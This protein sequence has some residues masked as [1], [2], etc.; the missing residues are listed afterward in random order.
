MAKR[1]F[2]VGVLA[3]FVACKSTRDGEKDEVR[4]EGGGPRPVAADS[5]KD[6]IENAFLALGLDGSTRK[7]DLNSV[8]W[9]GGKIKVARVHVLQD[10]ILLEGSGAQP[11]VY[12]VRRSDLRPLWVSELQEPTAFPV[13]ESDDTF[14]LVSQHYLHALEAKTGQRAMQF[15]AGGLAGLRRPALRLPFTPSGGGAGQN[16]TVYVASLGSPIYNKTLESF[17]LVTGQRGWG[18]RTPGDILTT[19][20]VGGSSGDPKLYWVTSNGIATCIDARNYAYAPAGPRWEERLEADVDHPFCLTEDTKERAGGVFVADQ[21]GM[22]YCLDRITG[23]RRWVSATARKPVGGPAVFGD[24]CVV[25]MAGGFSCFDS[26][27]VLY[28]VAVADGPA[29]GATYWVGSGPAVTLGSDPKADMSVADPSLAARHLAFEVQGEVLTV[30]AT[31]SQ[32]LS[33]N[34]GA[35]VKN[36]TAYGGDRIAVGR[37]VLVVKDR[38]TEALWHDLSQER[39]VGRVGSKLIAASGTTLTV[40]D[41][42]SGEAGASATLPGA[43]FIGTNTAD[44]ALYAVGGDAV[45]YG[46]FPR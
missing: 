15:V 1:L 37:T 17:S 10:T 11:N 29:K 19:P 42:W 23:A 38:G 30:R 31:G 40:V 46:F 34:G 6:P 43:R 7:L 36:A 9:K 5:G 45:L 18:Y 21:A 32:K 8:E 2:V 13:T 3:T 12:A 16:D 14:F 20:R 24:F 28:E 44:G 25:P 4:A 22:V 39:I 27:N 35:A 41:A 33:V 26:D